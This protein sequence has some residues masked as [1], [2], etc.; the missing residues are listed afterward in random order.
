[1]KDVILAREFKVRLILTNEVV[2]PLSNLVSNT[3][4]GGRRQAGTRI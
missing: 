2:E 4:L 3:R 1:V